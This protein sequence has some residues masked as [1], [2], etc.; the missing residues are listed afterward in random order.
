MIFI[1]LRNSE[2]PLLR[3]SQ[4]IDQPD[5]RSRFSAEDTGKRLGVDTIRAPLARAAA[6]VYSNH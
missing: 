3:E 5:K 2:H 6:G 4:Q 1:T